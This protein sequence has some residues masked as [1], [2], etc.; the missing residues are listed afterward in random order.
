MKKIAKHICFYY[1]EDRI[2]YLNKLIDAA[3]E[4]DDKV[5]IFIHTHNHAKWLSEKIHRHDNLTVEIIKHDLKCHP[6]FLTWKPRILMRKQIE[7]DNYDIYMYVEDDILVSND[8][9]KYWKKY[10]EVLYKQQINLGF[11]RTETSESGEEFWTDATNGNKNRIKAQNNILN[12]SAIDYYA[13][14]IYD[15]KLTKRMLEVVSRPFGA[16]ICREKA[17]WG[18]NLHKY[19]S[20]YAKEKI[21][22]MTCI[23]LEDG[24]L[25]KGCQVYHL[26]NNYIKHSMFCKLK[27]KDIID[28]AFKE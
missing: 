28:T 17:A 7:E 24:K 15:K 5:D 18:A 20:Q 22:D 27:I 4:Y 16:K 19:D 11:I 1:K 6:F 2:Q 9:I 14:W 8:N 21:F 23:P 3:S 12:S 10:F 26:P 25:P 13:F